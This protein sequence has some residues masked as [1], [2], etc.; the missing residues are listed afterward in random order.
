MMV[1]AMMK[2][3]KKQCGDRKPGGHNFWQR[4]QAS[5]WEDDIWVRLQR[6]E[7]VH[8]M[9]FWWRAFPEKGIKM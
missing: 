1:W 9:G 7:G 3:K 6:D 5:Q 2:L 4:G 8:H